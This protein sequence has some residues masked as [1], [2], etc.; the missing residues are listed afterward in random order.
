MDSKK[1]DL[2]TMKSSSVKIKAIEQSK[3]SII[4]ENSSQ[5]VPVAV[6]DQQEEDDDAIFK[7]LNIP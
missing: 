5:K 1:E 6:A 2:L 7:K 4:K 3:D